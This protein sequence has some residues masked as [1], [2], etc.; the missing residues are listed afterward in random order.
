MHRFALP[1]LFLLTAPSLV[2]AQELT[3]YRMVDL[4]HAYNAETI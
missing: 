1:F 3:D 2:A 4:T